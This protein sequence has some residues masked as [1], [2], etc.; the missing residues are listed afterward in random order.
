[1]ATFVV[2]LC[3][4]MGILYIPY[5]VFTLITQCDSLHLV[6]MK[7]TPLCYFIKKKY[8]GG[9]RNKKVKVM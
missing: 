8:A 4:F 3:N 2:D 6:K 1:M 9:R 7:N 5:F